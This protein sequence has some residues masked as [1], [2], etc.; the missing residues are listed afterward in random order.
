M[1]E[2]DATGTRSHWAARAIEATLPSIERTTYDVVIVGAG[3]V[4]CATAYWLRQEDRRLRVAVIDA[5]GLAAGASGRNA[6]FLLLGTDTNYMSAVSRYGRETSRRIWDFTQESRDLTI[7]FA[8]EAGAPIE[9]N[10]AVLAAGSND[11]AHA[12]QESARML[13]EDG[14]PGDFL[15]GGPD[16]GEHFYGYLMDE[17]GGGIDPFALVSA[18][19]QASGCAFAAPRAAN[20]IEAIEGGVRIQTNMGP[21]EAANVCITLNAFL[22]QLLPALTPTVS[23]VRAQMLSTDPLPEALLCPLY[24]HDGHYYVRQLPTGEVLVGGARHLHVDNEVGYE[25]STSTEL[26]SDL[27][28]YLER[29]FPM[30]KDA[31]VRDRWSGVM[32]FSPSGLPQIGG[33]VGVPGAIWAGGFTGHGMGFGMRMGR[34]LARAIT[35]R[36]D[37]AAPL[38]GT[39]PS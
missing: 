26:Q 32:G 25:D 27:L 6:G 8:A 22:P 5:K 10:G 20:A 36:E 14:F 16:L 30:W 19:A 3:I 15:T 23:A 11:E 2:H 39:A 9:E 7:G 13:L 38:F 18:L 1:S 33:V 37:S 29:H 17:E 28:A 12:L 34:L 21:I 24:S 4:G 35:G 31:M